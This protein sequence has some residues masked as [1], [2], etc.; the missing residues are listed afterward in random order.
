MVA[1]A[2]IFSAYHARVQRHLT[3]SAAIFKGENATAFRTRQHDG[4]S[5][6]GRGERFAAFD[7]AAPGDGIPVIRVNRNATHVDEGAG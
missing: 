4:L 5:A 6:E 3:M 7:F 2:N 1:A